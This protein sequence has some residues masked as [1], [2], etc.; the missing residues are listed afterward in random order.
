MGACGCMDFYPEFVFKGPARSTYVLQIYH[1]CESCGTPAGVVLYK[2]NPK[3]AREW[4]LDQV[5]KEEISIVGTCVPVIDKSILTEMT[6]N[7]FRGDDAAQ[8]ILDDALD[9][10]K[11][12]SFETAIRYRK[13][14]AGL[15]K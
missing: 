12:A 7:Q 6:M 11:E 14:R 15:E 4:N 2:M 9:V 13:R 5:R 10:F 1:S 3:E 8:E